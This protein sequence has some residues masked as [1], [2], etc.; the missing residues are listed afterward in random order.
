[1]N[2][3]YDFVNFTEQIGTDAFNAPIYSKEYVQI[4]EKGMAY[5]KYLDE[6][7]FDRHIS[8]KISLAALI[9]S[10]VNTVLLVLRFYHEVL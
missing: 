3:P 9:M 10:A 6:K 5:L 7:N 4:T 8:V 1:M 2:K